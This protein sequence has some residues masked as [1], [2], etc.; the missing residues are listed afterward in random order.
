MFYTFKTINGPWRQGWVETSDE[1][2]IDA[3]PAWKFMLGWSIQ[4][5]LGFLDARFVWR[6]FAA[7]PSDNGM[8]AEPRDQMEGTRGTRNPPVTG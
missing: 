8:T 5:A 3:S 4:R 6:V 7:R 2:V 1:K